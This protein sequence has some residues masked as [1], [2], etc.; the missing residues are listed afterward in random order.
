MSTATS[1]WASGAGRLISAGMRL[2]SRGSMKLDFVGE[3]FELPAPDA[4]RRYLLYVHVPFCEVLC[5]FCSF[6][7]VEFRDHKARRHFEALRRQIRGYAAAGFRLSGVYVGGG[8]PTVLPDEL[9]RTLELIHE[10]FGRQQV[11]VETNPSDLRA[12]VLDVLR[13]AGVARLSVGVQSF[14]D[15]LLRG[16]ERYDKYG[17]GA[18][19]AARLAATKGAFQTLNVDMIF[20]LPGQTRT[21]LERDLRILTE[22][23]A[24]DQVS[25]YPLMVTQTTQRK[26]SSTLGVHSMRNEQAYYALIRER[27]RDAY[28]PSSAWCFSRGRNM[29]DEYVVTDDEYIGAGSGAFG[30]VDGMIYGNSFSLNRYAMLLAAGRSPITMAR[31][32]SEHERMRYD[33]LMR[34]FGLRLE[35]AFLEAK[36]GGSFERRMWPEIAFFRALGALRE[37]PDCYELTDR[38][39][40]YWV[41]MMRE[42]FTGVNRFREQARANIA[43]EWRGEGEFNAKAQRRKG[44]IRDIA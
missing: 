37:R 21:R 16:M 6:H 28:V 38:G 9:A 30:Y 15:A 22:E 41:V 34:L 42:F 25:F 26:M 13:E 39:M 29:I 18:A 3:G 43:R 4:S 40:Y 17:S 7:R 14:D 10:C 44:E 31:R 19:F 8:T 23:L 35:K 12:E 20:N 24:V 33:F 32:L 2:A 1:A 27:L 11:S 36:Y 5:P